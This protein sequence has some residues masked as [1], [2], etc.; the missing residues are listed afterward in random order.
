MP[1]GAKGVRVEIR[2]LE[3]YYTGVM[4]PQILTPQSI[5]QTIDAAPMSL[6]DR[7]SVV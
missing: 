1:R 6:V 5:K 7:K 4:P 3:C 2:P